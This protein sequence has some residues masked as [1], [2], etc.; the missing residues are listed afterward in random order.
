MGRY[1]YIPGSASGKLWLKIF[2]FVSEYKQANGGE[3][4]SH[5]DTMEGVDISSTS[6]VSYHLG[7]M[8]QAGLITLQTGRR[9]GIALV[10]GKYIP[11]KDLDNK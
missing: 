4:P 5:R 9:R 2:H 7:H 11:P 10:G 3:S 8:E 6:V 1:K